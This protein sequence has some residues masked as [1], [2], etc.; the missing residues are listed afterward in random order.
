[1]LRSLILSE[2]GWEYRVKRMGPRTEPW[3]TPYFKGKGKEFKSPS[4]NR[5]CSVGKIRYEPL[6]HS[7][8]D[9]K[10]VWQPVEAR[11]CDQLCR[12]RHF[13]PI[14]LE[15]RPVYCQPCKELFRSREKTGDE[16]NFVCLLV[17]Y[18]F[19][20]MQSVSNFRSCVDKCK[21]CHTWM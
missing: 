17:A 13:D 4:R 12:K 16:L 18:C 3:G 9:T 7:A 20:L 1:M 15:V 10:G 14:K 2:T 21:C 11:F 19:S 8:T 6:E 5:L